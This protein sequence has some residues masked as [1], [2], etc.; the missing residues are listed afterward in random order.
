MKKTLK[1]FLIIFF[2]LVIVLLFLNFIKENSDKKDLYKDNPN[3]SDNINDEIKNIDINNIK[4]RIPSKFACVGEYCDG[5]MS[6]DDYLE[7]YT[8]LKIPLIKEGGN[9][10]CG[11]GMFFAPHTTNKTDAIL[12]ATYKL[13][14]D[15]KQWP[16]IKEDGFRNTVAAF[17]KTY[18]SHVILDKNGTAR[19]YLIGQINSPDTCAD[20]EFRAQIEQAAL[21]FNT[22][23]KI[24]VYL[25]NQ[26]F[27]WCD[28]DMSD[29]EGSCKDGPQYWI[30]SK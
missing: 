29:G 27:D 23:K 19:V 11:V 14:F 26:I 2:V 24:E 21:Q 22:V 8:V 13:L 6:G 1:I 4:E 7:K 10:G 18:Y 17:S 3:I 15:I 20:P 30:T 16:E 28:L 9:I 12:D 25:N 5:S